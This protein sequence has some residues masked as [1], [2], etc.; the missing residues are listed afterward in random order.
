MNP[1]DSFVDFIS[2][3][4]EQPLEWSKMARI[5]DQIKDT[6]PIS[7]RL[8]RR[9]NE[10]GSFL[11][12]NW[13]VIGNR[14]KT[15]VYRKLKHVSDEARAETGDASQLLVIMVSNHLPCLEPPSQSVL[16]LLL[17]SLQPTTLSILA[18]LETNE[19][20]RTWAIKV[21]RIL[22]VR[23]INKVYDLCPNN[24]RFKRWCKTLS[25]SKMFSNWDKEPGADQL[26]ILKT[27]YETRRSIAQAQENNTVN[28]KAE[29][30]G[31]LVRRLPSSS[32]HLSLNFLETAY[33][34]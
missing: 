1:L 33:R 34:D 16:T 9:V 28:G 15:L 23:A 10:V 26:R 13:A 12:E 5:L 6:Y 25:D 21:P 20:K 4:N 3:T 24:S 32:S 22:L 30:L 7:E 19:D 17:S 11:H 27:L 31:Y 29:F 14:S 2:S 18:F 8:S